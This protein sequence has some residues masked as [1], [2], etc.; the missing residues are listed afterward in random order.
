MSETILPTGFQQ[1]IEFADGSRINGNAYL[2]PEGEDLW[3]YPE[4]DTSIIQACQIFSNLEKIS[5]I[6]SHMSP[7][8]NFTYEGFTRLNL[9]KQVGNKVEIR[10]KRNS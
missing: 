1:T 5:R 3:V 9:I 10:M 8:E 4:A 2:H 6:I 7:E